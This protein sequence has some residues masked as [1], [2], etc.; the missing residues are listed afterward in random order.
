MFCAGS[1]DISGTVCSSH[2]CSHLMYCHF[3]YIKVNTN[4]V[5][6][7]ATQ[8]HTTACHMKER[9]KTIKIS[10]CRAERVLTDFLS[11][12]FKVLTGLQ[13]LTSSGRVS[14]VENILEDLL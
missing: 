5:V 9:H 10:E 4:S 12:I 6:H 14:R 11:W 3:F 2:Q 7:K 1:V 13:L 8:K